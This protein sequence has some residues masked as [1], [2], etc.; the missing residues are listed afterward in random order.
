MQVVPTDAEETT[1]AVDGVHLSLL[2]GGD[3]M[4]VQHFEIEPGA[5]VPEHSHP[6]EQTGYITQGTLT[7]LVDGEEVAVGEGD[8]YAIPGD[9]PHAAENRGDVPVEGVDVFSPPREN[10]DW[11]D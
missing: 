4:N 2:A 8:S 7:F 5:A 10:P 9:E 1:E 6:H 3:E 11:K